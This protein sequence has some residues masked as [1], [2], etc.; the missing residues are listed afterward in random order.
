MI[1]TAQDIKK[2]FANKKARTKRRLKKLGFSA[3]EISEILGTLGIVEKID[4]NV[5]F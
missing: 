3:C 5:E 4:F 2:Q 1:L